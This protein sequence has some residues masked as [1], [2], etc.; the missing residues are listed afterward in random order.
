MELVSPS[1]DH[2]LPTLTSKL[3]YETGDNKDA[4][5]C[6]RHKS[7]SAVRIFSL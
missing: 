3:P 4:I 1:L 6:V 2:Q 5:L 7:P